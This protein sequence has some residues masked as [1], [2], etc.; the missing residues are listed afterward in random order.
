MPPRQIPLSLPHEPALGRADFLVGTANAEALALIDRWPDWPS[1]TVF[2]AG[3]VGAGKSHLVEIWRVASNA[4]VTAA[5]TIDV[6]D[7]DSLL[8][9]GAVAVE[10]LHAG[11]IDEAALFHLLNI[12]IEKN[13]AVLMT[14]RLAPGALRL[15]LADLVSR[16]R[17]AHCVEVAEPDDELLRR[18]LTKLLADRQLAVDRAVVDFIVTRMERSLGT[19]NLIVDRLDKEALAA[20]RAIT[21]PFAAAALRPIFELPHEIGPDR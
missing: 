11:P 19:A 17:A 15:E 1:R 18:V 14:S 13:A 6:S 5:A 4:E 3:P 12:A 21:V 2:L 9:S 20:G 16:L 7:V 8:R 10:D